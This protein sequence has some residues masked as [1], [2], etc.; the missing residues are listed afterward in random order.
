MTAVYRENKSGYW[1]IKR[2]VVEDS[3]KRQSFVEEETSRFI[4][5]SLNAYPQL[6][7]VFDARANKKEVEDLVVDAAEF[8]GVKGFKAKGKRLSN[9][10]IKKVEWLEPL[11]EDPDY[12]ALQTEAGREEN[13]AEPMIPETNADADPNEQ[14]S[15]F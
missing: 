9:Y 13:G 12:E 7:V 1:Y 6:R 5:L 10:A 15:L 11:Q 3:D 14:L 8:I 2:F 4:S